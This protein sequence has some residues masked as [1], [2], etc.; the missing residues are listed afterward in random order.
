VTAAVVR[1]LGSCLTIDEVPIATPRWR[2]ILIQVVA[3]G[4]CHTELHA[5]DGDWPL[6]PNPPCPD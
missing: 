1:E 4:V 3:T 5:M 6:K 2:E